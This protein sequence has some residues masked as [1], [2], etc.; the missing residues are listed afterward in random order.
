M[1]LPNFPKKKLH[2][3]ERIWTPRGARVPRAPL[4]SATTMHDFNNFMMVC[5]ALK[6]YQMLILTSMYQKCLPEINGLRLS[7]VMY[8]RS[9]CIFQKYCPHPTFISIFL[10]SD[11]L[12]LKILV[13]TFSTF[14]KLPYFLKIAHRNM[15]LSESRLFF[16]TTIKPRRTR[17]PDKTIND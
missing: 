17:E 12:F 7:F 14:E 10:L 4:R 15:S 8:I 16:A 6:C 5:N 11:T 9:N 2:E 3:I 13:G 1:N